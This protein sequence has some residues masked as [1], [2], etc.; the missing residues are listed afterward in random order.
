MYVDDI[1][2]GVCCYGTTIGT[3]S[4]AICGKEYRYNVLDLNRLYIYDWAGKNSESWLIGQ[5]F[6]WLRKL[7][8]NRFILVSYASIKPSDDF[9]LSFQL[10]PV[11]IG[12]LSLSSAAKIICGNAV[13]KT[14]VSTVI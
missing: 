8:P 6:K 11:K 2:A 10:T 5:S 12:R 7:H 4:D 14:S 9:K 13:F 3:V 1:L